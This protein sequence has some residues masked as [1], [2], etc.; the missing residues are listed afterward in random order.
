MNICTLFLLFLLAR[1]GSEVLVSDS[2]VGGFPSYKVLYTFKGATDGGGPIAP[3]LLARDGFLYGTA[4]GG[5]MGGLGTIYRVKD[6]LF[7]RLISF[8]GDNGAKPFQGLVEGEDG[9]LYGTTEFGGDHG[10]GTLYS[11]NPQTKKLTVIH[12]FAGGVLDG[13]RG[14]ALISPD[15]DLFI[16]ATGNGGAGDNGTLFTLDHS[17]NVSTIPSTPIGYPVSLTRVSK[18][19]YGTSLY[20]AN[21]FG[22]LFSLG[23]DMTVQTLF[24]FTSCNVTE[25]GG[26]G[27]NPVNVVHITQQPEL[28]FGTTVNSHGSGGKDVTGIFA[29]NLTDHSYRLTHNFTFPAGYKSFGVSAGV[30]GAI[31]WV[32]ST[33]QQFDNMIWKF[34]HAGTAQEKSCIVHDF[35]TSLGTHPRS[36]PLELTP[37]VL[38]GTTYG[39]GG[40]AN[41]GV[42]YQLALNNFHC[43]G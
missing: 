18:T 12:H 28:L 31:Y 34:E 3:P 11:L 36:S 32:T 41:A 20:G 30:D 2:D 7:E 38:Y 4:S 13:A 33:D 19:V 8:N 39:G 24:N 10:R 40:P 23:E 42:I 6:N 14:T 26:T 27:C 21:N 15:H 29:F 16:G 9:N 22:S 43:P 25:P 5:G 35:D 17:G 1:A 37:G